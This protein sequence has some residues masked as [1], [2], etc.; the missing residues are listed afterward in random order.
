MG[1]GGA[2]E[3]GSGPEQK[4]KYNNGLLKD[5]PAPCTDQGS[6]IHNFRFLL[7]TFNLLWMG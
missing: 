5:L 1:E 6:E 3:G 7:H 4:S 2:G